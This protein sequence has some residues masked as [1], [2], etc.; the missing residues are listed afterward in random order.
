MPQ[1][2]ATAPDR[3]ELVNVLRHL[4]HELRQPLSAIE[5]I[6]YYLEMVWSGQDER[7]HS[8]IERLRQMVQQASWVLEDTSHSVRA[9]PP[10]PSLLRLDQLIMRLTADLQIHDDYNLHVNLAAPRSFVSIDLTHAEYLVTSMLDFFRHVAQSTEPVTLR[11]AEDRGFLTLTFE[12]PDA[13]G[14]PSTLRR[15][16]D[17]LRCA[18]S[19][20][21]SLPLGS[22]RR[23]VEA[24]AGVLRIDA[25]EDGF[26]RVDIEFP[27]I[28]STSGER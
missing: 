1:G 26:L 7:V 6:A 27:T 24:N 16:L 18:D 23:T 15:L 2:P 25:Q 3:T 9:T 14:D 19:E 22:L 11:T 20:D 10:V 5:S 21:D 13:Q 12:T 4:A 8:Q 28:P 17:P